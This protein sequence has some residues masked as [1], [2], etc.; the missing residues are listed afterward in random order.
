M[1]VLSKL[2][3][4]TRDAAAHL[5]ALLALSAACLALASC[6]ST[7]PP[8]TAVN[9]VTSPLSVYDLVGDVGLIHDPTIIRQGS[10][11]YVL[12]TD[13]GQ[14]GGFLP[15][16]CSSDKINWKRCSQI[17]TTIPA[18]LSTA[19]GTTLTSLWAPDVSY[20]NGLYHVYFTA[21]VFGTSNSVIGLVTS[22]TMNPTDPGYLWSYQ[23]I[24]LQSPNGSGYNAIDPSILVDTDSTGVLSHVWLTYGSFF[25]GIAQREVNP[26]T[27]QLLLPQSTAPVQLAT[28]PS[29]TGDPVEGP[30]LVKHNGFYYLFVSFGACCN[31]VFTTDTYQIAVGRGTSPQGPFTDMA[32]VPMLNGGGTILLQ[33]AGEFTAPGG[34]DVLIDATDGDLIAFHAL[35][36]AQNGYDYLFVKSLT[37]PSDWP[38]ISN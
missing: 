2:F 28:R 4:S 18:S 27:G 19:L 17:F 23:G 35:S 29:V 38:V 7:T 22:P 33:T 9:L 10:N 5:G 3:R 36:N 16:F 6:S 32:G 1:F 20:F 26:L 34:E 13:G 12:S 21:S 14:A 8:G 11:Y 30:S 24:I 25:K 15:I 37:W 31:S